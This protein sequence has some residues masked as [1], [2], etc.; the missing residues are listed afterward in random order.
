MAKLRMAHASRLDQFPAD[1]VHQSA[2]LLKVFVL[3]WCPVSA[4]NMKRNAVPQRNT[5]CS[6]NEIVS[7]R[8]LVGSVVKM[9]ACVIETIETITH[10]HSNGLENKV[11]S[12]I[13]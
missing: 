1:F 13:G 8:V 6:N 2:K 10:L 7:F 4:E 9:S 12:S 11:K 5:K 3:N